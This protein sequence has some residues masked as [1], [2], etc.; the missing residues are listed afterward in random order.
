MKSY[1]PA[2]LLTTLLCATSTL[3]AQTGQVCH[4]YDATYPVCAN[5]NSGWGWE[6]NAACIS[7]S[8][9]TN[10]GQT[11]SG[12]SNN[13]SATSITPHTQVNGTWSQTAS[14]SVTSGTEI[15]F[16]PHPTQG[17]SWSWQGC[18]T[19][20]NSREHT[21]WPTASCSMTATYTNN[22][23]TQS[24]QTFSVN[25][26]NPCEPSSITPYTRVNGTW[27]QT[28]SASVTP[29]EQITFGPHPTQGGGWS[30]Q[31]CDSTGSSRE[32]SIWPSDSCSMTATYTNN[33]G[34]Q[35]T[36]TFDVV[37]SN[38]GGGNCGPMGDRLAWGTNGDSS[39]ASY[40]DFISTWV[41]YEYT[42]GREFQCDGCG[43]VSDLAS[44]D[45]YVAYYAYFMG[46]ALPDCNVQPSGDNLCTDG[47]QW[48]RDNYSYLLSLYSDY[49]AQTYAANP[50]RGVFW[51]LEGD[52]H[53]FTGSSQSNPLSMQEL[54]QLAADVTQ[55]IKNN[56]PNAKVGMNHSTWI[57]DSE[58]FAFWEAM[59]LELLDFVWT[60][61][62]GNN[63]GYFESSANSS[64]YNAA[65]A[66]YDVISALTGKKLFVDTSFGL[67][68]AADSWTG[69]SANELNNRIA[70]GVFAVNVTEPASNYQSRLN[71][72]RPQLN[73]LCL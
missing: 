2:L 31:G 54:G 32:H 55:A 51:L 57:P 46:Y 14:A 71:N 66:R 29:G 6:N 45:T 36:Q 16:G 17:G 7:A 19:N 18:G 65:T 47:A 23:G 4:W 49:A 13:C 1:I 20:G 60:T 26:S 27:N 41:G 8:E 40:L 33:C 5:N 59:P 50:N 24:T 35:S 73:S 67:S 3:Y 72:L 9:C 12:S 42:Q 25:V 21:I 70:E 52:F 43:M 58:A 62:V 69:I 63:N 61:G 68:Q 11:I 64:T 44:S 39:A 34:A 22:C 30:W 56:A 53:Q 28:A 38:G 37:V 48:I 10:N 15:T